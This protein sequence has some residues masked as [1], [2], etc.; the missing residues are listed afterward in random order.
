MS[1]PESWRC[2]VWTCGPALEV[3]VL[4]RADKGTIQPATYDSTTKVNDLAVNPDPPQ[5]RLMIVLTTAWYWWLPINSRIP[6]YSSWRI[7]LSGKGP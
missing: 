4:V 1:D 5:P 3:H 2:T 6:I 7:S